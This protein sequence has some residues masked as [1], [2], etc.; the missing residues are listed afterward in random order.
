M[1]TS[2]P[3]VA[4]LTQFF[5]HLEQVAAENFFCA[6]RAV[7]FGLSVFEWCFFGFFPPKAIGT[8]GAG[9]AVDVPGVSAQ[10]RVVLVFTCAT[11]IESDPNNN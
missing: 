2:E 6:A 8:D 10:A 11:F 7:W 5:S 3:T 9:T 1:L 4:L